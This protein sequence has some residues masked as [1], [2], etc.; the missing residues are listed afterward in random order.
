MGKNKILSRLGGDDQPTSFHMF[1]RPCKHI[2][3]LTL[4]AEH[5]WL[6]LVW[7]PTKTR[8]SF[9]WQKRSIKNWAYFPIRL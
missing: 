5:R 2:G 7:L 3:T 6:S 8:A 9:K 1:R 4:K